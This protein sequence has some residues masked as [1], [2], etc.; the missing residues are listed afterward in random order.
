MYAASLD[1]NDAGRASSTAS[2]A[3]CHG[4]RSRVPLNTCTNCGT[5]MYRRVSLSKLA[6]VAGDLQVQMP[7]AE[8]RIGDCPSPSSNS[9][10]AQEPETHANTQPAK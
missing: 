3:G 7:Q 5:R 2:T 4:V 6:A 1:G 9:D 8:E 10:L